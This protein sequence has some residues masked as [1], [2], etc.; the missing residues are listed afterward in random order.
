MKVN[1]KM[2]K[3][4]GM[5]YWNF[6]RNSIT[7]VHLLSLLKTDM[8]VRSLWMAINI[9]ENTERANFMVRDHTHGQMDQYIKE[10]LMK[11]WEMAMEIGNQQRKMV[12]FM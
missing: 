7:K 8:V 10:S 12:I 4:M 3:K 11:G 9:K 1:G 5:G 2:V 6:H